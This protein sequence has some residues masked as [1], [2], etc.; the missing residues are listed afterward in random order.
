MQQIYQLSGPRFGIASPKPN[1]VESSIY[2]SFLKKLHHT[3]I[4]QANK[5]DLYFHTKIDN[6]YIIIIAIIK[7]CDIKIL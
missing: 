5:T 4:L 1:I 2:I 3:S 6:T 7:F